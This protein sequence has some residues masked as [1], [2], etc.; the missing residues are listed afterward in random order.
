[1]L[2]T[3]ERIQKEAEGLA[4]S[5]LDH[6][7][8]KRGLNVANISNEEQR[9]AVEKILAAFPAIHELAE[10]IV[11]ACEKDFYLEEFILL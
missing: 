3:Q 2:T 4:I 1:M 9:R 7:L 6:A 10:K 8:A 5:L 11:D